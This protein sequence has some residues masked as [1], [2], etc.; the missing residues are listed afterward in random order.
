MLGDVT[1]LTMA[2]QASRTSGLLLV[3]FHLLLSADQTASFASSILG[4]FAHGL[5]IG[6]DDSGSGSGSGRCSGADTR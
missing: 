3:A 4:S 1:Y 2:M 5:A 6:A